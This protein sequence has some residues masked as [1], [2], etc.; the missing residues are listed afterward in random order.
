MRLRAIRNVKSLKGKRVLVRIDANV[1]IRRGRAVDGPQGK[2]ARAA[3]DLEWLRQHGART[4]VITHLGRPQ[5][6]RVGAYSVAPVARRLEE[7]LS[8]KVAMCRE[9]VGPCARR[10]AEK[11]E[12]GEILLLEN[13]RFYPGEE[14]NS[15][16]F[17]QGLS[18]LADL[19]VN[20][21]FAVSHRA[22]ASVDAIA[23][24]LPSYAGPLLVHEVSVLS[25]LL[26]AERH[27]FVLAIGG[28]KMTTK[29]PVL[30][31]L[32]PH[33]DRVLI[34]GALAH[35][36]FKAQGIAI[37]KSVYEPEGVLLARNLLK[38]WPGKILLPTD[39]YVAR[40]LS[41]QSKPR[42]VSLREVGTNDYIVDVGEQTLEAFLPVI[43]SAR[44]VAWNGPF[45]YTEV[46]AFCVGSHHLARAIAARTGKAKTVAGGGDT[47]P[48]IDSAKLVDHFTLLS[49][50][51]GAMLEFL[52]GKELPGV[53]AVKVV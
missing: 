9:A 11:L 43:Q 31:R 34:G 50:G 2:I 23:E 48:V 25:S 6:R 28:L 51:G 20:D 32:L 46:P 7:L 45:G 10:C 17:A 35:A 41:S 14:Q 1:P 3:V 15:R 4:V 5:G 27:P 47:L 42:L 16:S 22:H 44:M 26:H 36:F 33:V 49:T 38:D 18:A 24:E 37:G 12:E 8:T 13:L 39:V 53:E 40:R 52:A 30:E 29:L 19:Y 21:A